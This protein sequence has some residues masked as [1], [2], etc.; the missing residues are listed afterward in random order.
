MP[1][2]D[3][4]DCRCQ[5]RDIGPCVCV[6]RKVFTI[7]SVGSLALASTSLRLPTPPSC[8][9]FEFELENLKYHDFSWRKSTALQWSWGGKRG[10][11]AMYHLRTKTNRFVLLLRIPSVPQKRSTVPTRC[12]R[13]CRCRALPLFSRCMDSKTRSLRHDGIQTEIVPCAGSRVGSPIYQF[14]V[15]RTE[16]T[17]SLVFCTALRHH[18]RRVSQS[19]GLR[20]AMTCST[21]PRCAPT[22][23]GQTVGVVPGW[24]VRFQGV[25]VP[26]SRGIKRGDVCLALWSLLG[27][28][29][30]VS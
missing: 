13:L 30:Q 28:T 16:V 9:E 6:W 21:R 3:G 2:S 5:T 20:T 23:Y 11:M 12:T 14:R 1:S 17:W 22:A 15:P 27:S 10:T 7:P 8:E 19:A 24:P 26:R 29:I 25:G 4:G 18:V